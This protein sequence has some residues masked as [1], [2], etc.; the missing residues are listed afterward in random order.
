M[1]K[2]W[3]QSGKPIP[4]P[5]IVKVQAIK[6]Y[7]R[8]YK[9]STFVETGTYLGDMVYAIKD[10]FDK[11]F[12]IELGQE[13][14][15]NAQKRFSSQKHITI[16]QGDS[17]EVIKDVLSRINTP[18]LFW[19]DGHYSEG[20]TAKGDL[21]TPISNELL[22]IFNHSLAHQQIILVDDAR[23]FT[24]TNDYPTTEALADAVKKS[25][26]N[27]F[28]VEDDIFRIISD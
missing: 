12:S 16:W 3:I 25:G 23:C 28:E 11:I 19:L 13:L 6:E 7:A 21:D 4:P 5:H 17:G 10:D 22:H 26:F 8:K 2:N 20:I 18:C 24:G 9:I 1:L 27:N 15:F 14:F